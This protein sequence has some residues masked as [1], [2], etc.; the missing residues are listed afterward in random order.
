MRLFIFTLLF[1]S[2]RTQEVTDLVCSGFVEFGTE[3]G[4]DYSSVEVNLYLTDGQLV[5]RSSCASN[6]FYMLPISDLK[7]YYLKVTSKDEIL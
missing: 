1:M 4:V 5:E 2:L 3:D 6:G 7:D